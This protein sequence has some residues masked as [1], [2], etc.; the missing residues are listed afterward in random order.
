MSLSRYN[1]RMVILRTAKPSDA[2]G[3]VSVQSQTWLATYPSP[4]NGITLEDISARL[5]ARPVTQK[6][7]RWQKSIAEDSSQRTWVAADGE[8]IV[9][10]CNAMKKDD[11]NKIGA[12]YVLPGYQHQGIGTQLMERAV[13]WLGAG[14]EI[15][16]TVATY[17]HQAIRAYEK[18]GFKKGSAVKDDIILMPSGIELPQMEMVKPA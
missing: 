5:A 12:L 16:L 8:Q 9:A 17:N 4:E 7:E 18:Y 13:G 2:A 3:I 11:R 15:W 6:I 14:K 10:F 1:S